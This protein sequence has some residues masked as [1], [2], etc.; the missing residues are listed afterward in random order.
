MAT[1]QGFFTAF[2]GIEANPSEKSDGEALS[3]LVV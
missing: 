2:N 1:P 3:I